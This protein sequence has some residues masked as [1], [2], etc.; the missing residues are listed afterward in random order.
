MLLC[1]GDG[2]PNKYLLQSSEVLDG[3]NNGCVQEVLDGSNNGCVQE[4]L[5]GSNNG[6]MCSGG[7]RWL[8]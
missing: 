6:C 5:D 2:S 3:S 7:T 8:R 4:V 1:L